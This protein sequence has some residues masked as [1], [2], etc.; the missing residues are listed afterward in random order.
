MRGESAWAASDVYGREEVPL[1][2]AAEAAAWD[3]SA[4]EA[5]GIP[6]RVLMENAGRAAAQVVGEWFPRGQVVGLVGSG[7][8]GGDALVALRTLQAWG[9]DVAFILASERLP[10]PAPVHEHAIARIPRERA[11]GALAGAAVVLDGLLGTGAR[12]AAR[13]P[14]AELIAAANESGRPTVAL[15][16][17]SGVDATTGGVPGPA[18]HAAVTVSFGAPKTGL[19]LHPAR[20]HC[21]R[22]LAVEIGFPPLSP[23]SAGAQVVT[24]AWAA[25]RLPA[26]PPDAHKGTAGRIVL[27]VGG[28]GMAGAAALA[29]EAAQRAGAG[30]VRLVS[31]AANREVLQALVPDAVFRARGAQDALEMEGIA[32]LLAGPGLGTDDDAVASLRAAL[33]TAAGIPTVLDADALNAIATG[34]FSLTELAAGRP[35]VITPHPVELSRLTG[36]EV[37]GITADPVGVAR[38]VA[39]SSGCVVLLKG[40]PSV[41]AAPGERVLVAGVGSSDLASAGMGDQLAG[42]LVALLGAGAEPR[43]AAALAL[44][45]GGRAA[46]LAGLGRSLSPRDVSAR[47]GAAFADPGPMAPPAR[48]PFVTF[49]QPPRH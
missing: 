20:E 14:A 8:N 43:T 44:F 1:L 15:D 48:F 38:A 34:A 2:T 28:V 49:D 3:R 5:A 36:R 24:P 39:A 16:L 11:A 47:L 41:V 22:L 46:D 17:P 12:G 13:G 19:L 25:A 32:A 23:E 35:L 29:G 40:Q 33:A 9:R 37:S 26:R 4:R 30:L 18:I 21:G 6:E 27:L 45:Y 10:D 42:T 31:P 7:H